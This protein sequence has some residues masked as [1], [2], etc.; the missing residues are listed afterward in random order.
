MMGTL[1]TSLEGLCDYVELGADSEASEKT[2]L[3]KKPNTTCNNGCEW[4]KDENKCKSYGMSLFGNLVKP[5]AGSITK[6][7][8]DAML[9][10]NKFNKEDC[11]GDCEFNA[12]KS[13][14]E[15][16]FAYYT[17][18][19]CASPAGK[20]YFKLDCGSK[21]KDK[22]SGGCEWKLKEEKCDVSTAKNMELL[23]GPDSAA[24]WLPK[25]TLMATCGENDGN[26]TCTADGCHKNDK[27]KC[28]VKPSKDAA[29]LISEAEECKKISKEGTCSGPKCRWDADENPK[30]DM[31]LD[32]MKT[33]CSSKVGSAS[34]ALQ[35]SLPGASLALTLATLM[36]L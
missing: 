3:T 13:N 18:F 22:C 12:E 35:A 7:V 27:D 15:V 4:E 2:C 24:K 20:E 5:D 16:K 25:V 33:T 9:S 30:C 10:C 11:A 31:S 14:C 1:M 17:S 36:R 8:F 26:N 6:K 32:Y 23:F 34:K 28:E 29:E 19:I 21:T